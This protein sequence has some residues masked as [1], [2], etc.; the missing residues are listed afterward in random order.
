MQAQDSGQ[1]VR[2]GAFELDIRAGEL[3]RSGIRLPVQGRPLQVLAVLLRTPGQLVTTDQLRSELWPSDTFVDFEHGVRNAV[4]RLRAILRDSADKPRFV[5]TLP[6]RGYRFIAPVEPLENPEQMPPAPQPGSRRRATIKPALWFTAL[7]LLSGV[8]VVWRWERSSSEPLQVEPRPFTSYPGIEVHASFSPDGSQV[9]FSW[10]GEREDNFDVY[11]KSIG[12]ERPRRLTTAPEPDLSPAWSPRGDLIAF[13]R[14]RGDATSVY[15]VPAT[16]GPERRLMDLHFPFPIVHYAP[17]QLAWLPDGESLVAPDQESNGRPPALFV[18]SIKTGQKR[19]LT[20]PPVESLGDSSPSVSPDGRFLLFSRGPLTDPRLYRA[21]M[22]APEKAIAVNA[23]GVNLR[24]GVWS[25]GGRA[26]VAVGGA[27]HSTGLWLLSAG[28]QRP[29]VPL[30]KYPADQPAASPSS[31][32][33]AYT[34]VEWDANIW[35]LSIKNGQRSA[36]PFITST[37]LDHLPALSPNGDRVAFVSTRS[38]S[39]GLY[40]CDQ[41]GGSILKLASASIIASPHWSPLGDR[42]VFAAT[43][44]NQKNDIYLINPDG[45]GLRRLTTDAADDLGPAWSSNGEWIYFGSNRTGSFEIWR[46]RPAG[47]PTERVTYNGG[48]HALES[49]DGRFLYYAKSDYD[50]ELWRRAINGGR[51]ELIL[52]SLSTAD[53]F[54]VLPD[55]IV[56]IPRIDA[57][58]RSTVEFF[59][60]STGK[61]KVLMRLDKRPVWGLA[62]RGD[63]VLFTQVDREST[64][65]MIIDSVPRR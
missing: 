27:Q 6:R 13:A 10:N 57:A 62:A 31:P 18:W 39:Q 14:S 52:P 51:E 25:N 24:S 40:V 32:R 17:A 36:R 16:G 46:M 37:Y 20:F 23:E 47:G 4:A 44:D 21:S 63:M 49:D 54:A 61:T 34:R 2:F 65:L 26:I 11:V 33:L 55:G 42:L 15:V 50:T 3:R 28:G 41:E 53:N 48:Y 45:S 12:A 8:A 19:Q 22:A 59:E 1:I 38:G 60:F 7:L 43:Y 64:D 58:Q 35:R 9:A 56:F 30:V 5:E 29:P